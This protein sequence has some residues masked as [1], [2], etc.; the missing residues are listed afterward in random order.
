MTTIEQF[1]AYV[2]SKLN[3]MY[4]HELKTMNASLGTITLLLMSELGMN[5][6]GASGNCNE[7][8]MAKILAN[9]YRIE[10]EIIPTLN[11]LE[12]PV[13][14]FAL[15]QTVYY[16]ADNQI[17]TSKVKTIDYRVS[18]DTNAYNTGFKY[19]SEYGV[20]PEKTFATKAELV[21]DLIGETVISITGL[22][23]F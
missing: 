9:Q 19:L 1:K 15:D 7:H 6:D 8:A 13:A 11:G 16:L 14:K 5:P 2:E 17:I 20:L 22:D 12:V 21:C 18:T 23:L 3:C 10:N 4:E